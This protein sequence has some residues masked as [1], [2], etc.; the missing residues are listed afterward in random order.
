VAG[1]CVTEGEDIMFSFF[2]IGALSRVLFARGVAM[3]GFEI[4]NGGI[5]GL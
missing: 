4:G 2:I 3:V 5:I 1:V